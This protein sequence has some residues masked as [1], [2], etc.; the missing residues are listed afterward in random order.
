[1]LL[2]QKQD[3][4][5]KRKCQVLSYLAVFHNPSLTVRL[6]SFKRNW[7]S[8]HYSFNG[9]FTTSK[10]TPNHHAIILNTL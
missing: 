9:R 4:Q 8:F 3:K 10:V 5:T 7:W 6:H 2:A 1:M